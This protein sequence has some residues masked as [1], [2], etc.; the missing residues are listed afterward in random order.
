M[1]QH[2][3]GLRQRGNLFRD[4]L[5][6]FRIELVHGGV[7]VEDGDAARGEPIEGVIAPRATGLDEKAKAGGFHESSSVL[8]EMLGLPVKSRNPH[9]A[10]VIIVS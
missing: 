10:S 3:Y 1:P 8:R 5:A 9:H 6:T 7:T 4:S 2:R